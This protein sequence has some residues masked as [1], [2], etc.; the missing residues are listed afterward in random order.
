MKYVLLKQ[1]HIN[2]ITEQFMYHYNDPTMV[3]TILSDSGIEDQYYVR[4][5]LN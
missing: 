3:S 4:N 5:D 1:N 2:I